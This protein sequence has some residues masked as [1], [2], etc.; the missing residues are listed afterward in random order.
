M[1]DIVKFDNRISDTNNDILNIFKTEINNIKNLRSDFDDDDFFVEEF[2]YLEG[3]LSNLLLTYKNR[4][5]KS[6]NVQERF[7]ELYDNMKNKLKED[8]EV[9]KAFFFSELIYFTDIN[10]SL[11]NNNDDYVYM[12]VKGID[13]NIEDIGID[14]KN[15]ISN[16]INSVDKKVIKNLF[17]NKESDEDEYK[18]INV[19]EGIVNKDSLLTIYSWYKDDN[20][21]K[22]ENISKDLQNGIITFDRIYDYYIEQEEFVNLMNFANFYN[23]NKDEDEYIDDDH[24]RRMDIINKIRSLKSFPEEYKFY[25]LQL[26]RKINSKKDINRELVE[27]TELTDLYLTM[28]DQITEYDY[29]DLDHFIEVVGGKYENRGL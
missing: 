23:A 3:Y 5:W 22:D 8:D 29:E 20:L 24:F 15:L 14:N 25:Y 12:V 16:I 6:K 11:I 21:D 10:S 17:A 2:D 7:I 13:S 26:A 19:V 9:W 18:M 27:I 28:G 1:G 4:N